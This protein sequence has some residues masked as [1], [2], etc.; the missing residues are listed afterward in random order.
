MRS[1]YLALL[2]VLALPTM[3]GELRYRDE[4][5][6]SARRSVIDEN[7]DQF[8]S[9]TGLGTGASSFGDVEH[10]WLAEAAPQEALEFCAAESRFEAH[11]FR[12]SEI[13]TFAGGD[14]LWTEG[15]TDDAGYICTSD[16]GAYT[17]IYKV[18][19]IG[20]TGRFEDATGELDIRFEGRGIGAGTANTFFGPIRY[21]A[22]GQL[23]FAGPRA[24][25]RLERSSVTL[26]VGTTVIDRPFAAVKADL[27]A[28]L[29]PFTA[30]DAYARYDA[31]ATREAFL[32]GTSGPRLPYKV[33]EVRWEV[34]VFIDTGERREIYRIGLGGG[35]GRALIGDDPGAG[36]HLLVTIQMHAVDD[37]TVLNF[38]YPSSQYLAAFGA[39]PDIRRRG[40]EADA[41]LLT[42]IEALRE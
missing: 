16:G 14:Q 42:F 32:S 29:A 19:A 20:G 8:P 31:G 4:T 39:T 15:R 1:T 7:L 17:G 24:D 35:P 26:E 12:V 6:G 25:A 3:A 37:T 10:H 38:Y 23:A 33:Y 2:V 28:S 11:F 21:D 13:R 30:A 40:E 36:L 18:R 41:R 5:S 34:P 27:M 9:V 22:A